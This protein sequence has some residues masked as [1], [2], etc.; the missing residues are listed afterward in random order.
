MTKVTE[1]PAATG[2]N[3]DDVYYVVQNGQSKKIARSVLLENVVQTENPQNGDVLVYN[4]STARWENSTIMAN[5]IVA[6]DGI[7]GQGNW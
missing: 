7:L 4:S 2:S 3:E 6:L 5:V 1:F